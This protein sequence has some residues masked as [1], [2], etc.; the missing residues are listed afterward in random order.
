MIEKFKIGIDIVAVD[1]FRSKPFSS[2]SD[3]YKKI[4][5]P[6]EIEYCNQF[7]DPS[8]HFAGKFALKEASIKAMNKKIDYLD[9]KISHKNKNPIIKTKDS[10]YRF[11]ASLS[12]EKQFAVGVV[13]VD[14]TC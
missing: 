4:F 5:L 11:I 7:K 13:I 9:I 14:V 3:F 10:N 1:R 2:N 6:D 8:T 12:H